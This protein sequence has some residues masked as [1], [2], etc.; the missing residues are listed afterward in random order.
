[1]IIG[2]LMAILIGRGLVNILPYKPRPFFNPDL[3][4]TLPYG[5]NPKWWSNL[6]SFPSDHA[7]LFY[8]VATGLLYASRRIGIFALIYTTFFICLPRIYLGLHYPTDILAGAFVGCT[9]SLAT[10]HLLDDKPIIL[11]LGQYITNKPEFFYPAFFFVT[12]QITD[13][14]ENS[15][16]LVKYAY[17]V[18]SPHIRGLFF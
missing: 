2:S 11:R 4:F 13:M 10:I 7:V 15:R 18:L 5:V 16:T 9:V 3:I 17:G 1:M 6:S 12:Y 8:S 14:F